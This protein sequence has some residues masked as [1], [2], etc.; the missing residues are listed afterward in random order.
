MSD[1][2]NRILE[3]IEALSEDERVDLFERLKEREAPV[4]ETQ[5]ELPLDFSSEEFEGRPDYVIIFDGGSHGNPGPG[6]GSYVLR[7]TEDG[8][9]SLVRLDFGRTMTNNEAE[10]EALIAALQGLTERVESA[11]R[12]VSEFSVE[13]RGD[14]ALVIN[15][16]R[17]KWKAKDDRMHKL[18]NRARA[19]LAPFGDHRLVQQPREKSVEVLGH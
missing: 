6:Y 2:V 9:E 4:A 13:I 18:R 12:S 15:Q 3:E 7:R 10:Y 5:I 8:K 11:R 17:G 19:L 1:A 16:V 14:S